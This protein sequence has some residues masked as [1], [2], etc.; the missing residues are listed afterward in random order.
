MG[1]VA[2]VGKYIIFTPLT[3][4]G[5]ACMYIFGGTLITLSNTLSQLF[6][7]HFIEAFLEYFIYSALPPTSISHVLFQVIIGTSIAGL[8]WFIAM[9]ARGVPL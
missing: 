2:G 4:V 1:I 5:F 9:G 8:K 7:G 3:V 6:S